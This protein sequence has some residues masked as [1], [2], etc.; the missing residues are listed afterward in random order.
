MI[1]QVTRVRSNI[2]I[3]NN[4][5]TP[6]DESVTEYKNK[7][8]IGI[9]RRTNAVKGVNILEMSFNINITITDICRYQKT[10]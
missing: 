10:N 1:Y 4:K 8:T 7:N 9:P 6:D 5:Q 2:R 3:R